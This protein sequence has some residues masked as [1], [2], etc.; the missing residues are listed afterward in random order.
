MA[1]TIGVRKYASSADLRALL[2]DEHFRTA[3]HSELL[4]IG[5]EGERERAAA[6]ARQKLKRWVTKDARCYV[7]VGAK[8]QGKS[9]P[10]HQAAAKW[11]LY[12][13]Q[14]SFANNQQ[15]ETRL[16]EEIH[17]N[18][19]IRQMVFSFLRGPLA[20]WWQQLAADPKREIGNRTGRYA[21]FY[22]KLFCN[23]TL[24]E[25]FEYFGV[26]GSA[27]FSKTVTAANLSISE[28]AAFISDVAL[29][30]KTPCDIKG[31]HV[32]GIDTLRYNVAEI[33]KNTRRALDEFFTL[34][35]DSGRGIYTANRNSEYL[36]Q[37]RQF[38]REIGSYRRDM[39]Y[40]TIIATQFA[41]ITLLIQENVLMDESIHALGVR[42]GVLQDGRG[43][44][45]RAGTCDT[46]TQQL[47]F[48]Q[49]PSVERYLTIDRKG[50]AEVD[51]VKEALRPQMEADGNKTPD[52]LTTT[53]QSLYNH[54]RGIGEGKTK[55]LEHNVDPDHEWTMFMMNHDA[56]V[57]AGPSGTTTFTLG[58][59]ELACKHV[60]PSVTVAGR[61]EYAVAMA[62]FSFWQRKKNL[63]KYQSSV[64]TWNEVCAALDHH[65][66][67]NENR[68]ARDGFLQVS[69]TGTL[70]DDAGCDL[71]AY[72]QSFSA[73]DGMPEYEK[74]VLTFADLLGE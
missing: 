66:G 54:V 10:S 21:H 42:G 19:K 72:P 69:D 2:A 59:V 3:L 16:A 8:A 12:K 60:D 51:R 70:G 30:A 43:L 20:A 37:H 34:L 26:G 55:R 46:S 1:L 31:R 47:E 4:R 23:R 71:Y 39:R 7:P 35:S 62:L 73:V 64:H 25:G 74:G 36:Q 48:L 50:K 68:R 45:R 33:D 22:S 53:K 61:L 29:A 32:G 28:A 11:L 13:T 57:G 9:F 44:L 15:R 67:A 65:R 56:V 27:F 38:L 14:K 52:A 24:K 49:S 40:E 41:N 18:A 5:N 58:L 63:L 6:R 17:G